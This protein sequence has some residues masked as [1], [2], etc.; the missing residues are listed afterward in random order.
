MQCIFIDKMIFEKDGVFSLQKFYLLVWVIKILQY[1]H[2]FLHTP[3]SIWYDSFVDLT[4]RVDFACYSLVRNVS[5]FK[6]KF[7][8]V[9]RL[10]IWFQ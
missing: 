1:A 2:S 7:W 9:H 8:N 6:K 4:D 3:P 10:F 5:K